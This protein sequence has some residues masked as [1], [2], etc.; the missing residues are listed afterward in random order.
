MQI[1][2]LKLEQ[3][4]GK[5]CK[6]LIEEGKSTLDNIV[7]V[8][9]SVYADYYRVSSR[10]HE[11]VKDN[12]PPGQEEEDVDEN[13]G[14]VS[15][16]G[17]IELN[18]H[19][20][21]DAEPIG[22]IIK[23]LRSVNRM[24]VKAGAEEENIG[25]GMLQRSGAEGGNV[26]R[27]E[28]MTLSQIQMLA[29]NK[30]NQ[31][32]KK[33]KEEST[34]A[35]IVDNLRDKEKVRDGDSGERR[36]TEHEDQI[37]EDTGSQN[38]IGEMEGDHETV[39]KLQI[40]TITRVYQRRR[41]LKDKGKPLS[42]KEKGREKEND[43]HHENGHKDVPEGG[44]R[45]TK[46]D[47][48]VEGKGKESNVK[49]A[50]GKNQ[51]KEKKEKNETL[52]EMQI[53]AKKKLNKGRMKLKQ[54]K[55]KERKD[56]IE[57][58]GSQEQVEEEVNLEKESNLEEGRVSMGNNELLDWKEDDVSTQKEMDEKE[59]EEVTLAEMRKSAKKFNQER[60][61][62][63]NNYKNVSVK[64]KQQDKGDEPGKDNEQKDDG[65]GSCRLEGI[66]EQDREEEKE[67]DMDEVTAVKMKR[68]RGRYMIQE[69]NSMEIGNRT[70]E[71][72]DRRKTFK[73]ESLEVLKRRKP[74]AK[75]IVMEEGLQDDVEMPI[76]NL[77]KKRARQ[78]PAELCSF[79]MMRS[80]SNTSNSDDETI[81]SSLDIVAE[82][83]F[84]FYDFSKDRIGRK[85]RKGQVWA[86]YDDKDGMPRHYAVVDEVVSVNPFQVQLNWLDLQDTRDK[87]LT[88][89]EK[90]VLPIS[91]GSFKVSISVTI[92]SWKIFSHVADFERAAREV[93]KIYPKKGSVWAMFNK[94]AVDAHGSSS[95]TVDIVVF[96][97]S[98]SEIYGLSMAYLERVD[99]FKTVYKRKQ[100]GARA[101]KFFEGNDFRLFS[102]HIPARKLSGEEVSGLPKDCW[103]LD[104]ASL[105]RSL[106][107][108]CEQ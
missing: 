102:H 104:H 12:A 1:A 60:T 27:G 96:L 62:L 76:M 52:A 56:E 94:D 103:E 40:S 21:G 6:D 32:R 57:G 29:K 88:S 89:R 41:K 22:S 107:I 73:L 106:A 44:G 43:D 54:G 71:K 105:P 100:I 81:R 79:E 75:E 68:K 82:E 72:R 98:Y 59:G 26:T 8:D 5:E 19:E 15:K 10:Y 64:E 16:K 2:L 42:S 34:L 69:V 38:K 17:E 77:R 61:K 55:E 4:N 50:G 7:D 46:I 101:I 33:L 99:G 47:A 93:Y 11:W 65:E 45:Q 97:T 14:L 86:I 78:K 108:D 30:L 63:N 90:M 95:T 18:I 85:F 53:L 9:P 20:D 24:K 92:K 49:D 35:E 28:M 48:H 74:M 51:L 83:D 23:R 58:S 13:Q 70:R 36:Q 87:E 3:G 80:A 25:K 31:G 84:D 37:E 67:N 39:T 91:C 66:V